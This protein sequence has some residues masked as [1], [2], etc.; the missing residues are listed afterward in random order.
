ML[1][2]EMSKSYNFVGCGREHE[3]TRNV[4]SA[5][6]HSKV[7]FVLLIRLICLSRYEYPLPKDLDGNGVPLSTVN[8][9]NFI[10]AIVEVHPVS[11]CRR[12]ISKRL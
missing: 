3:S 6:I 5:D 4:L 7:Y 9:S 2:A 8:L 10:D 11:V 12:I 1:A